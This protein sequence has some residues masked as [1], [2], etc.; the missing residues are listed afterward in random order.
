MRQP[1]YRDGSIVNLMASIQVG[2]GAVS[3]YPVLP[4]LDPDI[5]T[6][7]GKVLL[8]VVDGLGHSFLRRQAPSGFL[9]RHLVTRLTSV[10]PAT[11]ASAITTFLTGSAPQQH[12]ITG[13]YMY[14]RELGAV[15]T[16]LPFRPRYGAASLPRAGVDAQRFFA[17]ASIFEKIQAP[18]SLIV[19]NYIVNSDFT[20]AHS[21]PAKRLGYADMDGF[22]RTIRD[23]LGENAERG[24]I[25]AY[26]A[27]LDALAHE[28]GI[29]S[30]SVTEHF[31]K[32]ESGLYTLV[33]DLAGSDTLVVV[34]ADHGLVD[35]VPERLIKVEEHPA[36]A[37]CLVLPLC[38]EPRTAYCYVHPHLREQFVAYCHTHLSDCLEV[39]PS[40]QL[41]DDGFFGPGRPHPRL[42]DRVG[43]YTLLMKENFAIRDRVWG[44]NAHSL[45]GVHGGMSEDEMLVPLILLQT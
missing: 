31:E 43:H 41:I 23:T 14:F 5:L 24:F 1:N 20:L 42:S 2:L 6:R 10:F 40:Q 30:P 7:S 12:G 44:E 34:T 13:W 33:R 21:G 27:G 29:G 4:Q 18:S 9:R 45:M 11:T 28:Q 36:L 19:P 32:L 35:N 26:W 38:G 39:R 16:V 3:E 25:H 15:F 37:E 17:H 8:V 22:F